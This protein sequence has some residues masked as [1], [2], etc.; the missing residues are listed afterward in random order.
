VVNK[1]G[2]YTCILDIKIPVPVVNLVLGYSGRPRYS[3][4]YAQ[5]FQWSIFTAHVLRFLD[6]LSTRVRISVYGLYVSKISFLEYS[7]KIYSKITF[8]V[9]Y[10]Y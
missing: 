5:L 8:E 3:C 2:L 9:Q 4:V 10:P 1:L 6:L 7:K